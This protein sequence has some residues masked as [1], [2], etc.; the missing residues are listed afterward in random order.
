MMNNENYHLGVLSEGKP[1]CTNEEKY[2][3]IMYVL[4]NTNEES[5]A[6]NVHK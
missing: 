1:L 4:S 3:T 6:Y 2:D 5:I